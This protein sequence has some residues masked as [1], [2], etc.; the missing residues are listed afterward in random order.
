MFPILSISEKPFGTP[1]YITMKFKQWLESATGTVH[2]ERQALEILGLNH[3]A[4]DKEINDAYSAISKKTH[5][6]M[7]GGSH[8]KQKQVNDAYEFLMKRRGGEFPDELT[9]DEAWERANSCP[10]G[11]CGVRDTELTYITRQI[12]RAEQALRGEEPDEE[13]GDHFDFDFGEDQLW[14]Y[15]IPLAVK[16][17]TLTG[18][19]S[20]LKSWREKSDGLQDVIK[21]R[22]EEGI[23]DVNR[24]LKRMRK[25]IKPQGDF[26]EAFF[27]PKSVI[28]EWEKWKVFFQLEKELLGPS[29]LQKAQ[30]WSNKIEELKGQKHINKGERHGVL[31]GQRKRP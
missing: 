31:R 19:D 3:R 8:E 29:V 12:H 2:S 14:M 27:G 5:P 1:R 20:K 21:D 9:P 10:G 25:G 24:V 22:C 17:Y 7:K 16:Y 18:D 23:Y 15:F 26:E 6:D 30:E 28:D 13:W 11:R 4:T